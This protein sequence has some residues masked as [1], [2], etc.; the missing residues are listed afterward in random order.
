MVYSGRY[1]DITY[2]VDFYYKPDVIINGI[3][4]DLHLYGLLPR[5]E[6]STRKAKSIIK[7]YV[8]MV[9]SQCLPVDKASYDLALALS[10]AGVLDKEKIE[11]YN[12]S[13]ND[14]KEVIEQ[15][16]KRYWDYCSC[17]KDKD[18]IISRI[19][20]AI[21][22]FE[23]VDPQVFS[24]LKVVRLVFYCN[25]NLKNK[26]ADGKFLYEKKTIEI[27]DILNK[28]ES[29]ILNTLA[30]ETKHVEQY[31]KGTIKPAYYKMSYWKRPHEVEAFEYGIRIAKLAK[32]LGL[33]GLV[34]M[35]TTAL[36]I[37]RYKYR[38]L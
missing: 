5:D 33:L 27:Y 24:L 37:E 12:V 21:G 22:A 11:R 25:P 10:N 8:D 38:S 15:T 6:K 35:F 1:G 19:N 17:V 13:I 26:N 23:K 36:A 4:D 29:L 31:A 16:L 14:I 7:K 30:H 18:K 9:V 3:V 34:F 20:K 32:N 2:E 28:D